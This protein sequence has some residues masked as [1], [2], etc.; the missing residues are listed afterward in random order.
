MAKEEGLLAWFEELGRED[1][2][3][4]I[5]LKTIEFLVL[6]SAGSIAFTIFP[7]AF[8]KCLDSFGMLT[9]LLF[10]TLKFVIETSFFETDQL[11]A[12]S[13]FS[14]RKWNGSYVFQEVC[15]LVHDDRM[16]TC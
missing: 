4:C 15:F 13:L 2:L 1:T 6:A 3:F 5:S 14:Y 12:C 9:P 7:D 11:I 16:D 8:R 10:E